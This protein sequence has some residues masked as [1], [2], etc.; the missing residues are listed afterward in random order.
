[1]FIAVLAGLPPPLLSV[2]ILWVNLV[3]D[4]LP[5]MTLGVDT[6]SA[7]I[8]NRPSRAPGESI[9]SRGVKPEDRT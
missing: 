5:A 4:G 3:T 1:M 6:N 7:D 2:Q 8:M 9:F